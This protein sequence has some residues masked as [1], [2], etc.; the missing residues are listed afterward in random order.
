M[1]D[2]QTPAFG[3]VLKRL[4]VA[5]GLSQEAL[6]E[7][8]RMSAQAISAL[9]RGVRKTPYRETVALLADALGLSPEQRDAL[10]ATTVR[11]RTPRDAVLQ[12][13][14][15]LAPPATPFIGRQADLAELSGAIA[16]GTRL[17]TLTGTGGIGKTRLALALADAVRDRFSD[18]VT[19]VSLAAIAEAEQV[20]PAVASTIGLRLGA[21]QRAEDSIINFLAQQR[22]LLVLDNF[23]QVL[24]ARTLL[25]RILE[26]ATGVVVLV[27]SRAA[28][29]CAGER[30]YS[31]PALDMPASATIDPNELAEFAGTNLFLDRVRAF[32]PR[33]NPNGQDARAIAE[34]CR[35]LDGL[36]LAIELAAP[37]TR[38][39]AP[40]TLL[41]RL[42][43]SLDVLVMGA[44]DVPRHQTMRN[45]IAWSH[46]LLGEQDRSM[47]RRLGVFV[48]GW[49]VDAARAVCMIDRDNAEVFERLASLLDLNLLHQDEYGGEIRIDMLQTVHEFALEKLEQSGE[50]DLL[51]SRLGHHVRDMSREAH[52]GLLGAQQADWYS[53]LDR[54]M[55]NV[56]AALRWAQ[57]KPEPEIGLEI[58]TALL[59]YWEQRGLIAEG[60]NWLELF[61]SLAA[62]KVETDQTVELDAVIAAGVLADR[63][64]DYV[65]ARQLFERAAAV[66]RAHSD[67]VRLAR[68]LS[69]L[70]NCAQAQGDYPRATAYHEEALAIARTLGDPN[71][72]SLLLNNYGLTVRDR[73]DLDAAVELFTEALALARAGDG[74]L[75]VA[76]IASNLGVLQRRRGDLEAAM[77]LL[78][79]SAKVRADI[80]DR[81]GTIVVLTQLGDVAL[82][83][84]D[85]ERADS[86]YR[87]SLRQNRSVCLR[88]L[89]AM[90]LE[91]AARVAIARG[92]HHA[93]VLYASAAAREREAIGVP[94]ASAEK[95]S[96]DAALD[97]ALAT[98]G[99]Q[100]YDQAWSEGNVRSLHDIIAE[101]IERTV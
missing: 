52:D 35:R 72:L 17:L 67:R 73:G 6:A 55:G 66:A 76:L 81:W 16:A 33:F 45:A 25:E 26:S 28:L 91:G 44:R 48:G 93:G 13:T 96:L 51:R 85:L 59:R 79:D 78:E 54:E 21:T 75:R 23:E 14:A 22:R 20:A 36:P 69:W 24:P 10:E 50:L 99:R 53:R 8:A 31:V 88:E 47:F 7:R 83:R 9:E 62:A 18:G 49:S 63:S 94:R 71:V 5:A 60:K 100:P 38:F 80:D 43:R 29:R 97:A 98:L 42:E 30:E 40:A 90:G 82:D 1:A 74:P 58:T 70:G 86:S 4:R 41:K 95:A 84:G 77:K 57:D 2:V 89:N 15:S 11:R 46:D 27:T 12:A 68:S 3:A 32:N 61:L 34:I 101:C 64:D 56:R 19:V 92:A 87:E 37:L 39:Y 65:R